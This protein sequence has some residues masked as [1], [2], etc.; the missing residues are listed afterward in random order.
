MASYTVHKLKVTKNTDEY[1]LDTSQLVSDVS[2]TGG[3]IRVTRKNGYYYSFKPTDTVNTAGSSQRTSKLYIV[4]APNQASSETT[5]SNVNAYIDSTGNL[6]SGNKPVANLS[7]L[8]TKVDK[9]TGKGLSTNDF[10]DAY[11]QMLD[12]PVTASIYEPSESI[13]IPNPGENVVRYMDGLTSE[14]ELIR[15]NFSVSSENNP[16]VSLEW[17][18]NDDGT[19][20]ITN[21]SSFT[22]LETMRPVFAAVTR[23][24][25]EDPNS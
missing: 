6:Y 16:P 19:F 13:P 17:S 1:E 15:W 14:F 2:L 20:Q 24:V 21:S 5:Y 25:T 9:I 18:T 12:N 22:T 11:K 23:K 8:N 7:D 4:G 3:S 10:T